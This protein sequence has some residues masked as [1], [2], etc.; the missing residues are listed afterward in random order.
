MYLEPERN[1][2][3]LGDHLKT[4]RMVQASL[5]TGATKKKT[6]AVVEATSALV[7][8]TDA[9]VGPSVFEKQISEQP[10]GAVSVVSNKVLLSAVVP[11]K[12]L[13]P[14]VI[15]ETVMEISLE[16][17]LRQK[18]K[19]QLSDLQKLDE[20]LRKVTDML[21]KDSSE[22]S[23]GEREFTFLRRKLLENH[24][25]SIYDSVK[26]N[27]HVLDSLEKARV[28][29]ESERAIIRA[30]AVKEVTVQSS[31]RPKYCDYTLPSHF[32]K[33]DIHSK[34]FN[35]KEYLFDF[36][37]AMNKIHVDSCNFVSLLVQLVLAADRSV[38]SFIT[39]Q[40]ELPWGEA[41]LLIIEMYDGY[42]SKEAA[43]QL[44]KM[45]QDIDKPI[46]RYGDRFAK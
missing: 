45:R 40:R 36:E 46:E 38:S 16:E 32:P 15:A 21:L 3:S 27:L 13:L 43:V 9:G 22:V 14:V 31:Q 12:V 10:R 23:K 30:S 11:D 20:D 1:V 42:S 34:N 2:I 17:K 7:G 19:D 4:I 8:A 33:F 26:T 44:A 24:K 29:L 37:E 25:D 5:S 35:V 39:K 41:K 6:D 18:V 28:S